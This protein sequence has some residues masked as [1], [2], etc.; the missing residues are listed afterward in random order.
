MKIF[1]IYIKGMHCV[2][3]EKL[4][5]D[6][7]KNVSGVLSVRVDRKNNLAELGYENAGDIPFSCWMGMV[8][9]KFIVE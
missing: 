8:R 1:T 2:S 9:G 3:C 7:F 5:E 4:L 6:E